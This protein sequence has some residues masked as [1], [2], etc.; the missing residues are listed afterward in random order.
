[1]EKASLMQEEIKEKRKLSEE[2]K[3]KID[4]D[5][6]NN[7]LICI[8]MMADICIISFLYFAINID[9]FALFLKIYTIIM[10][11]ITV[12]TFEI[13]YRRDSLKICI[14]GIEFFVYSVIILCL[15]YIYIYASDRYKEIAII[16]PV[17]FAIYYLIKGILIYRK[18]QKDYIN[19]L[20]DVKEIL[21]EK[22]E[23]YLDENSTKTLREQKRKKQ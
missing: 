17:F 1:L 22:E 16:L 12:I 3:E 2:V 10:I 20:S 8:G 18:M 7:F 13:A 23:S 4:K 11:I 19:N 21:E 5:L 14:T 9:M 6:F 15:N